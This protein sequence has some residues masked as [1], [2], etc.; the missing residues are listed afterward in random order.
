M[1]AHAYNPRYLGNRDWEDRVKDSISTNKLNVVV[2][3]CP[4]SHMGSV[5][6][7]IKVWVLALGNQHKSLFEK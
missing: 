6:R 3:S 7:R 4:P 5:I 2:H 1:V